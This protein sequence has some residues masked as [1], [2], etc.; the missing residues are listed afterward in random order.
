VFCRP[1]GRIN[2]GTVDGWLVASQTTVSY[3]V[4]RLDETRGGGSVSFPRSQGTHAQAMASAGP[5]EVAE[6]ASGSEGGT[7]HTCTARTIRRHRGSPVPPA[8]LPRTGRPQQRGRWPLAW[9]SSINEVSLYI[10]AALHL[11]TVAQPSAPGLRLLHDL[12][13]ASSSHKPFMMA[14]CEHELSSYANCVHPAGVQCEKRRQHASVVPYRIRLFRSRSTYPAAEHC[15]GMCHTP[16]T[17][18][19]RL[20]AEGSTA[21]ERQPCVK[22]SQKARGR[23]TPEGCG[24]LSLPAAVPP[25]PPPPPPPPARTGLSGLQQSAARCLL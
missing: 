13:R 22:G 2:C 18:M 19:P 25:P 24:G 17:A 5:P 12:P 4:V 20:P 23:Q 16:S 10:S 8:I 1:P 21:G 11:V 14:M 7:R 15:L 3:E 6:R 9:H